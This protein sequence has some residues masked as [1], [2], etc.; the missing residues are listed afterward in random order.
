MVRGNLGTAQVAKLVNLPPGRV[1]QIV[2]AWG[3]TPTPELHFDDLLQVATKGRRPMKLS[4]AIEQYLIDQRSCGRISSDR[5]AESYRRILDIHR[6]DVGNRDPRTIGREDVKR[7]LARWSYPNTQHNT[8]A[9]LV[10]FYDWTLEEGIRK[11]N[12]ARQTRRPKKRPT[13]VYR[14]TSEEAAA[15]LG[16]AETTRERRIVFLGLCAGL[17]LNELRHMQGKHFERAGFVWVS[18]DIAK[19]GRERW[20]PVLRDLE[21]IVA[22]IRATVAPEH[23]VVTGLRNVGVPGQAFGVPMVVY[24]EVP[25][26]PASTQAVWR[27]VGEVAKRAG[28]AAHI[29]TH[30][31]RHAYGDHVAKHAGLLNAQ[32][33]MGHADPTTTMIYVGSTSLED[34]AE[35]VRGLSY[36]KPKPRPRPPMAG[37]T[38]RRHAAPNPGGHQRRR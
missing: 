3:D 13:T 5:S 17:R 11:D 23:F 9:I 38:G 28:I 24:A 10:S 2:K 12:P 30:L 16:A 34:L 22:D 20:V 26:R 1:R 27:L 35:A 14:L 18:A 4:D 32:A 37:D 15:I 19:G 7:T 31:L 29:H 25:E 21:P 33:L 36:A 6:R 8:R